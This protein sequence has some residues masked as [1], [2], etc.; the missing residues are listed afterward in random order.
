M[1]TEIPISAG[2]IIVT[3]DRETG[4]ISVATRIGAARTTVMLTST[5][6]LALVEALQ[7]AVREGES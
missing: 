4:R 3:R 5:Q 2:Q 7:R 1:S 6:A